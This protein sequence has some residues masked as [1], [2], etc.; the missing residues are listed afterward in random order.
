MAYSITPQAQQREMQ[1]RQIRAQQEAQAAAQEANAF[2]SLA[3]M[4]LVDEAK[5]NPLPM[6]WQ[7]SADTAARRAA[8]LEQMNL[9]HQQRLA[10]LAERD[11]ME[12]E[13]EKYKYEMRAKYAPPKARGGGTGYGTQLQEKFLK[14]YQE[15]PSSPDQASRKERVLGS[16]AEALRRTPQGR[17]FLQDLET[18]AAPQSYR[19]T[20]TGTKFGQQAQLKSEER[21]AR[22]RAAAQAI[23]SRN[24]AIDAASRERAIMA[25]AKLADEPGGAEMIT[26][27]AVKQAVIDAQRER[28]RMAA[29]RPAAAP[30]ATARAPAAPAAAKP[31]APAATEER[32]TLVRVGNKWYPESA[33][34]AAA[35]ERKTLVRRGGT[36]YEE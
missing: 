5:P 15:E 31:A 32:K 2:Q 35:E 9:Q 14:V 17:Q 23:A 7:H 4:D 19:V 18:G 22:S 8:Q 34:P 26:D 30:A 12:R 6:N 27:P 11:R 3:N 1:Q 20:E 13:Q 21:E 24:A 16:Y 33:A 25:L 10:E 36:W 29:G 28:S